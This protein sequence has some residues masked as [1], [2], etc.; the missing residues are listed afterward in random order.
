MD[1]M[2]IVVATMGSPLRDHLFLFGVGIY[3]QAYFLMQVPETRDLGEAVAFG[4]AV[5]FA[6]VFGK[7]SY[8]I[9]FYLL[10][11]LLV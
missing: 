5:L 8:L 3:L 2:I 7:A 4:A 6:A 10:W 1:I 11:S 9:V